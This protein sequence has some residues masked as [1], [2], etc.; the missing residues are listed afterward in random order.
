M[1]T[2]MFISAGCPPRLLPAAVRGCEAYDLV[3]SPMASTAI[4]TLVG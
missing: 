1:K 2:V 4:V 3:P